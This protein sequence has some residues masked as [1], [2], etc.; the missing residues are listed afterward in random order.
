LRRAASPGHHGG[1]GKGGWAWR[2]GGLIDRLEAS[3]FVRREADATDR[4][5]KRV[6]ITPP[7]AGGAQVDGR[8]VAPAPGRE[9]AGL[10]P[11]EIDTLETLLGRMKQNIRDQLDLP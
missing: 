2:S 7:G 9:F 8:A 4:R 11:A 1:L 5:A 3:G 6:V 10:A